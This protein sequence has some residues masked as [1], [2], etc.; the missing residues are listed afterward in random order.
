M[1]IAAIEQTYVELRAAL[2][3]GELDAE[4]FQAEVDQLR[5]QDDY[6]RYWMIGAQSGNWYYYD[7]TDWIQADPTE[8]ASL[9]FIDEEGIQW[10]LGEQDDEWY[11]FDGADW[12]RYGEEVSNGQTGIQDQTEY[13]LDDA[14]RYWAIGAKTGQWYYYDE[15]GWHLS[16]TVP[17]AAALAPGQTAAQP[18]YTSETTVPF[19]PIQP[20]PNYLNQAAP[21]TDVQQAYPTQ[22]YTPTPPQT[23]TP[24]PQAPA[25]DPNAFTQPVQPQQ[26]QPSAYQQPPQP[27]YPAPGYV[28]GYQQPP[29]PQPGPYPRPTGYQAQVYTSQPYPQMEP[30]PQAPPF[31]PDPAEEDDDGSGVWYYYP[32]SGAWC[33]FDGEKWIVYYEE[34]DEEAF[35]DEAD[36]D[37]ATDDEEAFAAVDEDLALED[38]ETETEAEADYIEVVEV[39]EEDIIDQDEDAP[40]DAEFEVAVFEPGQ[41]PQPDTPVTEAQPSA[42]V[43][44]EPESIYSVDRPAAQAT[45]RSGQTA[46][47]D[48]G[49]M[50][51]V[52][53]ARPQA[54]PQAQPKVQEMGFGAFML[55]VPLW[56]W[57]A[58]SGLLTLTLTAFVIVGAF[59]LV[60]SRGQ[61]EAFI[62]AQAT[63]TL[64]GAVIAA[65]PTLGPTPEPTFTPVPSPT[66][67]PL[68]NYTNNFLGLS[69]DYPDGWL[70][71]ENDDLVIFAP[72]TRSLDPA[73]LSGAALWVS[74]NASTVV[75]TVQSE[76]L[77]ALGNVEEILNEGVMN[78]GDLGWE[79]AQVRLN[80]T[81]LDQEAIAL[82][83]TTATAD[84]AYTLV[85]LAP[86]D[87][88]DDFQPL[89]DTVINS[90]R[91]V[92]A[93]TVAAQAPTATT[94]QMIVV[95]PTATDEASSGT[96]L[97]AATATTA[98]TSTAAPTDTVTPEP[99]ESTIY[100]VV[101]G[102][103]LSTIA[104]EFG[105]SVDDLVAANNL[106][107]TVLQVD[108]ELLVPVPGFALTPTA[109]VGPGDDDED[110]AADADTNE[111][112]LYEVTAG[113]TLGGIA[114]DF[115]VSIADLVAANELDSEDAILQIGQ[116]LIIPLGG[117][118]DLPSTATPT[119]TARATATESPARV[120]TVTLTPTPTS[121]LTALA[122]A[123]ETPTSAADED[124]AT[125]TVVA[126][127][128]PTPTATPVPVAFDPT[129]LSGN[130][131]Y[132]A[133][134]P[135]QQ[136]YNIWRSNVDGSS[137][138]I[139]VPFASQPDVNA[140]GNLLAYRSWE[141]STRGIAF[142]DY[143]GGRQGLL[144][145]FIEDGLPV[146]Q[147]DGT[148]VFSSRRESDRVPRL[149][150]VT[151]AGGSGES[152]GFN[153]EHFD[154]T[155][156]N[157]VIMRGCT[158]AGDCGLWTM[159]VSGGGEVK[160]G[161][162]T[163]DTAPAANPQG[164]RI[165]LMSFDR[166]GASNWEIWTLNEDGTDPQ[167]L[168]ENGANDG[169][170]AWSPDGQYI[171]FVSDRDGT[172]GV[173][174]MDSE[175]N[176]QTKL[177][178]MQGSPQGIVGFDTNNSRGWLEERI[179]WQP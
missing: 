75:D 23:S 85:A 151:Q 82:V 109:N 61:N 115:D 110:V 57:T 19:Q 15:G 136:V 142:I 76:Q 96:G 38:E 165:A 22:P 25:P 174:V 44:K 52:E 107:G 55:A 166:G 67:L 125:P 32:D 28:P 50:P 155:S 152:I 58:L 172:W 175:G 24:P 106:S 164:G 33:Y 77:T 60:E 99:P 129:S 36:F 133:F 177:F 89:F 171:A 131:I 43:V 59:Y 139:I 97:G 92:S 54:R 95:A 100:T 84:R 122:Q 149:Y 173:W 66:P 56:L 12:V 80:A 170:P 150:R 179:T 167:R 4:A 112:F 153:A 11:Y 168:T 123:Q 126:T 27:G 14:G 117:L 9:P 93:P 83:A 31:A 114:F 26:P 79:S 161:S 169:L 62:A 88:W 121:V 65:T 101:A 41:E 72:S 39:E 35:E 91:F 160:I 108:Q 86:T 111:P 21:N 156:D 81:A 104:T 102:D 42:D 63:P 138:E 16:E 5:L 148:L 48:T 143:A 158:P 159:P 141:P 18:D 40:I 51:R 1:D 78:V 147:A 162:D 73:A 163:S 116:T 8:A 176:N 137:Q 71:R 46:V 98:A 103:T 146:W 154:V 94:T 130:I 157:R 69:I 20:S 74:L 113:D 7:G 37:E 49:A 47:P 134:D 87:E 135:Q 105:V 70:F 144:T 10:V 119:A 124:D 3:E 30:V 178:T 127:V 2:E 120:T 90:I 6:G 45:A 140:G 64:P 128:E 17:P 13:F 118:A 68:S 29:Q 34:V 145:N 132:P 53:P